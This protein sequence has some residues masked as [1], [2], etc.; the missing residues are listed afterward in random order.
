MRE[1]RTEP[2]LERMMDDRRFRSTD[3]EV[4]LSGGDCPKQR[5]HSR[6]QALTRFASI[7]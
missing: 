1:N 2:A 4:G 7:T 5:Q 6:R 3:V